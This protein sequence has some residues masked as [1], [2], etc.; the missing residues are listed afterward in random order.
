MAGT[1]AP[2]TPNE[3]RT[4]T[5]KG[6]SYLVPACAF[7]IIGISTMTLP[8]RIVPMACFQLM[9]AGDQAGRQHIGGNADAH[10]HPK[11]RVIIDAP[12]ALLHGNRRQVLVVERRGALLR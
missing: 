9:P 5:G 11:R 3:A 7:K 8:S 12:G 10:G 6:M 1:F 2:R 4:R